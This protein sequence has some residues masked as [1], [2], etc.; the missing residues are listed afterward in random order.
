MYL[1]TDRWGFY[2]LQERFVASCAIQGEKDGSIVP[3][4]VSRVPRRMAISA[5][6]GT[7]RETSPGIMESLSGRNSG[8]FIVAYC[9][10]IGMLM[11]ASPWFDGLPNI[12]LDSG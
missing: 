9:P 11:E 10:S 1:L 7:R 4:Q 5:T 6:V 8:G 12:I 2:Q 3:V